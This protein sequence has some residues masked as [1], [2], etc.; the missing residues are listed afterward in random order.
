[1]T[2]NGEGAIGVVV[3]RGQRWRILDLDLETNGEYWD[4]FSVDYQDVPPED[5][6]E[7]CAS[8]RDYSFKL[9]VESRNRFRALT[10]GML[11]RHGLVAADV[12][13]WVMQNLSEGA[14]RFYEG[15]FSI[16]FARACW[17]NLRAHGHLGSMD[18]P[19]NLATG[20]ESGEFRPGQRV[21]VLNN[22]PVA[23][24]STMLLEV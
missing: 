15:F 17:D 7:A 2:I 21:M 6:V 11:A 18:V 14:F 16:A 23:A 24:W 20:L 10:D 12:D 8:P 4:L 3:D 1:V 22:S 13:H 19:L 9:A 5:W